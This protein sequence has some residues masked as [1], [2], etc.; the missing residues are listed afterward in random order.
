MAKRPISQAA[1]GFPTRLKAVREEA[2]YADA[3]TF[4]RA[5]GIEPPAYRKWERGQSEPA[6]AH[7]AI[8]Q[9]LTRCSL[10]WLI[11]GKVPAFVPFAR[12]S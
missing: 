12:A 1:T 8:I 3:A 9:E 11:T 2:G 6:L 5:I 10:D 7:L 4:A